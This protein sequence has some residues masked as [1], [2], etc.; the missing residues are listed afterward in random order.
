MLDDRT[1]VVVVQLT[2]HSDGIAPV[3]AAILVQPEGAHE[4]DTRARQYD[5]DLALLA[6]FGPDEF[7]ARFY[8]AWD[9]GSWKLYD[10]VK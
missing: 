5:S 2:R 6:L 8:A 3:G 4:Y 10:R 1:E 9:G 7:E